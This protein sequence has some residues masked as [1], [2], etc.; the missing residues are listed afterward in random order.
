MAETE[1]VLNNCNLLPLDFLEK[2]NIVSHPGLALGQ[3]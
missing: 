2:M 1:C 3:V